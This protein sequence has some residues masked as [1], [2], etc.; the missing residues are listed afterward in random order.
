ME[1]IVNFIVEVHLYLTMFTIFMNFTWE[2]QFQDHY[3]L[4]QAI[5]P[6]AAD[7]RM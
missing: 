3:H 1:P 6:T 4:F 2:N 7:G 5:V